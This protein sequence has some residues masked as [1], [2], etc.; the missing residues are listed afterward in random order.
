MI[1]MVGTHKI[2]YINEEK[3]ILYLIPLA[4]PE[5]VRLNGIV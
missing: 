2:P 1:K 4:K 5:R 3:N